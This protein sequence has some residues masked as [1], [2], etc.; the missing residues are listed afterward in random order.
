MLSLMMASRL[1]RLTAPAPAA[2]EYIAIHYADSHAPPA[3]S[4]ANIRYAIGHYTL[5]TRHMNSFSL[6]IQGYFISFA[7]S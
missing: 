4:R 5:A 6:A 1:L 2:A 3:A 7:F